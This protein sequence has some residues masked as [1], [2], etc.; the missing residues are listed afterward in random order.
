MQVAIN[1]NFVFLNLAP[2]LAT[3]KE[4]HSA[5]LPLPP[6][7][8]GAAPA[9]AT[10]SLAEATGL[11]LAIVTITTAAANAHCELGLGYGPVGL[12]GQL[13]VA[14]LLPVGRQPIG[15]TEAWSITVLLLVAT[16]IIAAPKQTAEIS[17]GFVATAELLELDCF[18][19]ELLIVKQ[20]LELVTECATVRWVPGD[21]ETGWCSAIAAAAVADGPFAQ[22][23]QAKH[24]PRIITFRISFHVPSLVI[25]YSAIP[26]FK[27]ITVTFVGL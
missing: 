20:G 27:F 22:L 19:F 23:I 4:H 18:N 7:V 17:F 1:F 10:W 21:L 8:V 24:A 26:D 6:P 14:E 16:V 3:A 25:N 9:A 2:A 15:V 11:A 12:L 13:A 5:T